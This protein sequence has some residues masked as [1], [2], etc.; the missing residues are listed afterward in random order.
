MSG[1]RPLVVVGGGWLGRAVA[2]AN[3]GCTHMSQREFDAGSVPRESALIVASGWSSLAA[4]DPAAKVQSE[5][6]DVARLLDRAR[7]HDARIVVVGSSD[8]CGLAEEVTGTTAPNPVTRYGELKTAR[9]S[10][11]AEAARDGVD[12]VAVR[13]APTHGPGKAQTQRMVS[14]ASK[15]LVPLPRGGRYSVGFVTLADAVDAFVSLTI[16]HSPDIVSVGGGPTE[17]RRLLSELAAIGGRPARFAPVPI[18]V[19]VARRLATSSNGRLAWVG[20]FSMP[21]AVAME[22]TVEPSGL[23]EAAAYL[24]VR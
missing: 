23:P 21:R 16:E 12:A 20:R 24:A 10:L 7:E 8:V 22:T 1:G 4:D 6:D 11:V 17:L 5:L 13:L 2:A 3:P 9:E 14:L 19:A 15:P 18:P